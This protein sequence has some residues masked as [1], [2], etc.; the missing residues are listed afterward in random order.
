[1]FDEIELGVGALIEQV[2]VD[3]L[4]HQADAMLERRTLGVERRQTRMG[5]V[6]LLRQP[7]P[8]NK[9]AIALD[10]MVGEID[11]EA[12]AENRADN[13][14]R[15]PDRSAFKTNIRPENHAGFAVSMPSRS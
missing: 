10:Q 2:G 12:D 1:M 7:Q 6:D 4:A 5:F 8:G 9:A 15:G 13:Q 3:L 11:D 14:S